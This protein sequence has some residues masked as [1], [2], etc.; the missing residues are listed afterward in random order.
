[1]LKSPLSE[2]VG[3]LM[4]EDG[5]V[6]ART[7]EPL[8]VMAGNIGVGKSTVGARL[9]QSLGLALFEE[10]VSDNPYLE[11]FYTDMPRWV[12]HLNMF[13]LAHRAQ[14][15]RLAAA[16]GGVLDRSLHEDEIFV[17]MAR[18]DGITTTDNYSVF[19]SLFVTLTELLPR[20]TVLVY[21][22]APP[23]V[24]LDRIEAR[25]RT[26]EGQ[27]LNLTYLEALQHRYDEWVQRYSASSV[28]R[29]DTAAVDLREDGTAF[30]EL[31]SEV[32]RYLP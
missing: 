4:R 28:V 1:M 23:A 29:R 15:T 26:F 24:L 16:A 10:S 22:E 13:F 17:Q 20:P 18:D 27:T 2:C 32:R 12:F 9:A 6:M 7:P 3:V 19:E 5:F 11:R 30:E 21:L 8:I 31:R 25:Q 14:Q